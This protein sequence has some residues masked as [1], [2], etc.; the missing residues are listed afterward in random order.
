MRSLRTKRILLAAASMLGVLAIVGASFFVHNVTSHA[1]AGGTNPHVLSPNFLSTH[2]A[3]AGFGDLPKLA[4]AKVNTS[5]I[6]RT[7]NRAANCIPGIHGVSNFCTT[8]QE[9]GFDANGNPNT[10]WITNILGNIPQNGGT[11][12]INNPVIPVKVE[13]LNS[14]GTIAFTINP[15]KDVQPT[16]KS[17]VYSN[18]TYDSSPH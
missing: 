18:S 5:K 2:H 3:K 17:P 6:S 1:A 16:L 10:N 7:G 12:A 15:R 8:F 11:T 4:T 9:P 13:L 14:D